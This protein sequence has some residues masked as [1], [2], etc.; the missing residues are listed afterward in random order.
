MSFWAEILGADMSFDGARDWLKAHKQMVVAGTAMAAGGFLLHWALTRDSEKAVPPP[1]GS[2]QLTRKQS[3]ISQMEFEFDRFA[4]QHEGQAVL[5]EASFTTVCRNLEQQYPEMAFLH[6]DQVILTLPLFAAPN[7]CVLWL[8]FAK[9][10]R[11]VA[12]ISAVLSPRSFAATASGLA[13]CWSSTVGVDAS[14]ANC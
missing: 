9:Y 10:L 2:G 11:S 14:T 1:Q 3:S 6:R 13:V 12:G 7:I 8:G 4:T 5:S